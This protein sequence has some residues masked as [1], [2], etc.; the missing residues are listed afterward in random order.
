MP[1]GRPIC[2]ICHATF[3]DIAKAKRH[4]ESKH[5]GI[6]FKCEICSAEMNRKD[7]LKGH[8]MKKHAMS[9]ETARLLSE[10]AAA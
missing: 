4:F 5:S 2:P 10:N 6:V 8:L 9:P 1:D 7:V 3:S